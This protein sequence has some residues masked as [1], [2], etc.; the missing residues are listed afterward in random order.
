MYNASARE[1]FRI[2]ERPIDIRVRFDLTITK[3][4]IKMFHNPK[5]KYKQV[6]AVCVEVDE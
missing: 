1:H 3:D 6:R 2:Q 4:R 5:F